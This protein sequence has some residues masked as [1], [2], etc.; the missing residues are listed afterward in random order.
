ML[1]DTLARAE[2][3]LGPR[4]PQMPRIHQR[5]IARG[6]ARHTSPRIWHLCCAH[7][8]ADRGAVEL[9]DEVFARP[10]DPHA[11]VAQLRSADSNGRAGR[12]PPY[13]GQGT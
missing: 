11:A 4:P 12:Q 5:P 10:A 13:Q 3:L 6:Q 9:G 1:L 7:G 8:S 2:Q